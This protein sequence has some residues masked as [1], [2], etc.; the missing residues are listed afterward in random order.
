MATTVC[1]TG[2]TGF[3][4][5]W[6]V[7]EALDAGF[8]VHG[9]TRSETSGEFLRKLDGAED[10][11]KLFAGCDLMKEGS[12][13]EAIKG[14][15]VV[16]H[17]ASPFFMNFDDSGREKLVEPALQGTKTVLEACVAAGVQKVVLT[18][19]TAAVY[20]LYGAKPA[21]S[22]F[23]EDDWSPADLLEEK[24]NYYCLS[25]V[26]AERHAWEI[27]SKDGCPFKLSVMNPTMIYGP[28][29]PGQDNPRLHTSMYNLFKYFGTPSIKQQSSALVDVRD[30]A[31]AHVVAAKMDLDWAGW[32]KR[33][34]LVACTPMVAEVVEALRASSK[35]SDDR[36][37]EL[38]SEVDPE[39]PPPVAGAP[40]PHKTLMNTERSTKPTSEG[41]LGIKY[42]GLQQM[43]DDTYDSLVANKL[44][45]EE[46]YT[47]TK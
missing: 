20:M 45:N 29:L 7:K 10:R 3:L 21:D 13:D 27:A 19:S 12:F 35:V 38:P 34:L 25:K 42:I 4:G 39:I 2:A 11:L 47:L 16:I 28:I 46:K 26:L 14:C 5:S 8:T 31:H 41:G 6:V 32:G 44:D 1:V 33:N 37:A 22:H 23:T 17:T 43:V 30:V 15:S 40:P 24:K 18:S 9:T 36:K